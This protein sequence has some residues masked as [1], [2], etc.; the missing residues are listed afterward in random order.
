MR[1]TGRAEAAE[2]G[3]CVYGGGGGEGLDFA[4]CFSPQ[5]WTTR[6][7]VDAFAYDAILLP[8]HVMAD[9]HWALG[10]VLLR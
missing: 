8:L 5:R 3:C 7:E 1:Q 2:E 6:G 4:A 9:S 10:C